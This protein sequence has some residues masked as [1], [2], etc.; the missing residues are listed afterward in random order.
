MIF[1]LLG[2]IL[3]VAALPVSR[4]EDSE[5]IQKE[6]NDAGNSALEEKLG[7]LLSGA[8][9]VGKIRVMVMTEENKDAAGF[10]SQ[11]TPRVTGVLICAQGADKPVVERELK[12]AVEALFQVEAHKIKIMKM[13]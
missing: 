13:K 4:K 11:G 2:L 10:Y 5:E 7:C 8:E 3:S 6:E 1:L 12:E 9:D